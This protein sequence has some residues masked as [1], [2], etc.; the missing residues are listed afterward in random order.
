MRE[1]C[2]WCGGGGV[3]HHGAGR[4]THLVFCHARYGLSLQ[5]QPGRLPVLG[6]NVTDRLVYWKAPIMSTGILFGCYGDLH[7]KGL[8]KAQ[9]ICYLKPLPDSTH[10]FRKDTYQWPGPLD[11]TSLP[12]PDQASQ[13][14]PPPQIRKSQQ[15]YL[16]AYETSYSTHGACYPEAPCRLGLLSWLARDILAST[17]V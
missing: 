7:H 6:G 8:T 9:G 10:G 4:R 1:G 13:L 12:L 15:S 3:A 11:P 2:L 16:Q 14:P 5:N 17:Y